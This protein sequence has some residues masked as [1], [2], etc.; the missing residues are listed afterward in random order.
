MHWG[1]NGIVSRL[2]VAVL[3]PAYET[4]EYLKNYINIFDI[5]LII[6]AI[7]GIVLL[8]LFS[9]YMDKKFNNAKYIFILLNIYLVSIMIFYKNPFTSIVPLN[10]PYSY[11]QSI[12][13]KTYIDMRKNYLKN[14]KFDTIKKAKNKYDKII[15]V[16]GESANKHH[17]SIYGYERKT[18]PFLSKLANSKNLHIFNAIAP[19]NQTRFAVPLCFTNA[20]VKKFD[21]FLKSY[22][23]VTNFK[24]AGY[25]TYWLSSQAKTGKHETYITSIA[26]EADIKVI[27]SND[28]LQAKKQTDGELLNIL[29]KLSLNDNLEMYVFHLLGSHNHYEDRY[30]KDFAIYNG[31]SLIDKYDNTIIYTDY[32]LKKIFNHFKGKRILFIYLSDHAEIVSKKKH[33]HGFLPPYRDEFEIPFVIYSNVANKR[34]SSL[35]KK[36]RTHTIN[37]QCI[38]KA[39]LYITDLKDDIPKCLFE[40]NIF[41][42]DPKNIFNFEDL[43]YYKE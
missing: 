20:I 37:S 15:I 19:A 10:L 9:K 13:W 36:N 17:M 12:K 34:I 31:K 18:T 8:Y 35:F 11:F 28:W 43:K 25:K 30:P 2:E 40:K 14:A 29:E 16:M 23:I 22:S 27:N 5:M 4:I 41:S 3:S 6:Y 33:G 39:I 7:F 26:N 24:F 32:I 42:L 21:L 1:V 38:N